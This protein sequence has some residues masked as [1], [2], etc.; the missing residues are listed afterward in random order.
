MPCLQ[1]LLRARVPRTSHLHIAK[2]KAPHSA[3]L[4][5]TQPCSYPQ[6]GSMRTR[7]AM[8]QALAGRRGA[9]AGKAPQAHCHARPELAPGACW[10][11]R[12]PQAWCQRPGSAA[13]HALMHTSDA[14]TQ[15]PRLQCRC[16]ARPG[17]LPAGR[18]LLTVLRPLCGIHLKTLNKHGLGCS[19]VLSG[20]PG[21][22]PPAPS[23]AARRWAAP[24]R[25]AL[26]D[27]RRALPRGPG[28][29]GARPQ[30]GPPALYRFIGALGDERRALPG[31]RRR[32]AAAVAA[33]GGRMS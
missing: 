28:K 13:G 1:T 3:S 8:P 6:T 11:P 30:L 32:G 7:S 18:A 12:G 29:P 2:T 21:P 17:S 14:R 25:G 10:H 33:G 5:A 20:F 31:A 16:C 23:R 19:G 27:R 4:P 26:D 15:R 9:G 22:W 24:T